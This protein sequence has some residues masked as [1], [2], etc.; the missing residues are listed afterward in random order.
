MEIVVFFHME[1]VFFV[2]MEIVF[3]VHMEI[4][5]FVHMEIVLCKHMRANARS[6]KTKTTVVVLGNFYESN[7]LFAKIIINISPHLCC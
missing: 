4:V 5:F 2:H 7:Q 6:C 3:F 1:I